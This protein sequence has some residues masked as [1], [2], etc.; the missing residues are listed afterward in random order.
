MFFGQDGQRRSATILFF[1]AG[2]EKD[3]DARDWIAR[4][5]ALK[6]PRRHNGPRCANKENTKCTN[7][8][9]GN[10]GKEL[11]IVNSEILDAW[12]QRTIVSHRDPLM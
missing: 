2:R 10:R 6:Q 9:K 12:A 4:M 8:V 7:A 3:T 1:L 5:G 11:E